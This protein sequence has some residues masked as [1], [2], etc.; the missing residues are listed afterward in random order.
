MVFMAVCMYSCND[1]GHTSYRTAPF[2]E[3]YKFCAWSKK[4]SLGNY[5]HE[6][7]FF[8]IHVNLHVMEFP[9]IFG[10][11]NF[12]KIR[13][14]CGP[15][16]KS[17][18]CYVLWL[19]H[20]FFKELTSATQQ[21]TVHVTPNRAEFLQTMISRHGDNYEVFMNTLWF[22]LCHPVILLL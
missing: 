5:F 8:T 22:H 12:P 7:T 11:T 6:M 3:G 20:N 10:E 9:L 14:I 21:K 13:E 4:G 18:L 19:S 2:F 1:E 17:A 15:R 16:R